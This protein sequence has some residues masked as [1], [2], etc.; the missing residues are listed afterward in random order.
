MTPNKPTFIDGI[1]GPIRE[2]YYLFL[3]KGKMCVEC[4]TS[5]RG[6]YANNMN[7]CHFCGNELEET[8]PVIDLS[9]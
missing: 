9:G 8:E 2:P 1:L 3:K 5:W 4:Q 7:Y 6:Y